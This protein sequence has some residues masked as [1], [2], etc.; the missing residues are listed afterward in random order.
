MP[1]ASSSSSSSA[2]ANEFQ[3]LFAEQIKELTSDEPS[4]DN[5]FDL[6]RTGNAGFKRKDLQDDK[7]CK[8]AVAA[9][10][11]KAESLGMKT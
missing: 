3:K 1:A 5:F 4:T 9:I 10:L 2:S 8:D 7:N 6:L 11:D